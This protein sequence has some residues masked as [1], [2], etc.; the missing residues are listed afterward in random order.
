MMMSSAW[1]LDEQL[2]NQKKQLLTEKI[3]SYQKSDGRFEGVF[4]SDPS[5]DALFL[6]MLKRL[7]H[8]DKKIEQ[9]SLKKIF[10]W[11]GS[12]S[13]WRETPDGRA[14]FDITGIILY[15]LRDLGLD[16]KNPE[17]KKSW[18]WFEAKGGE[19]NLNLG[20]KILLTPL[21]LI[22][23]NL[24]A[25]LDVKIFNLPD[26]VPG[27]LMH[28]GPMRMLTVPLIIWQHYDTLKNGNWFERPGRNNSAAAH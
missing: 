9:E 17:L 24:S 18:E 28:Q 3:F 8:D 5:V 26:F 19:D 21:K 4:E 10:D 11:K 6:V 15:C 20:A 12:D 22:K 23:T 16:K 13:F 27:S 25:V 7:G 14:S 2:L 1:C